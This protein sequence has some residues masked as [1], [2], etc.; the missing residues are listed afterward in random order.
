[1]SYLFPPLERS[2]VSIHG[3]EQIFPVHR[4]YCVGQ[5]YPAHA[6]EMG[7]DPQREP[8]F[9]FAKPSDSIVP[10]STCTSE[11]T[12]IPYPSRTQTLAS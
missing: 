10:T 8:P 7:S 12:L 6:R 9:F 3:S 5:N 4:I 11:P 2:C 1:M